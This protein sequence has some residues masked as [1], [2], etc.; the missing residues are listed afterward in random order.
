MLCWPFRHIYIY[1]LSH[2][3]VSVCHLMTDIRSQQIQI[4]ALAF[5]YLYCHTIKN[6]SIM[7]GRKLSSCLDILGKWRQPLAVVLGSSWAGGF[8][9]RAARRYRAMMS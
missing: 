2:H 7:R 1:E 8:E 9:H 6:S 5:A 3:D 4:R